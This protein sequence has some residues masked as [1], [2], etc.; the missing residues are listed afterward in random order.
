MMEVAKEKTQRIREAWE[1]IRD[2]RGLR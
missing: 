2:A 1:I